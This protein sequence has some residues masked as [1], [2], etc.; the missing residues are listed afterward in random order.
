MPPFDI[1]D[2]RREL[3]E[4]AE[5]EWQIVRLLGQGPGGA[6]FLARELHLDRYVALKIIAP[7]RMTGADAAERFSREAKR[8]ASL[9]HP[10]ILPIYRIGHTKSGLPFLAMKHV[11]GSDLREWARGQTVVDERDGCCIVQGVALALT[12]AHDYNLAHGGIKPANILLEDKFRTFVTDFRLARTD[13]IY[14]SPEQAGGAPPAPKSDVYSLGVV[15][16]EL[17]TG[18]LPPAVDPSPSSS[19]PAELDANESVRD[20]RAL[21]PRVAELLDRCISENP[22]DRPDVSELCELRG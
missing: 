10:R 9:D 12:Y 2:L 21:S 22:D 20:R 3:S 18:T 17:L 8:A 4:A 1:D 11:E 13:P 7:H 14:A 16:Y 6:V 15:A 19:A 5:P